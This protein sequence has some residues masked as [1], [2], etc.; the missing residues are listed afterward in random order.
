MMT[1]AAT[2]HQAARMIFSMSGLMRAL[3]RR[4][5]TI[6]LGGIA[7]DGDSGQRFDDREYFLDLRLHVDERRLST[8]LFQRLARGDEHP[9]ASAADELQRSQIEDHVLDRTGQHR[10]EEPFQI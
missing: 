7:K 8:A 10:R 3:P 6:E 5:V 1:V 4:E 9:Q 2:R